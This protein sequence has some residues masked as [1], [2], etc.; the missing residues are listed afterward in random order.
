[1]ATV[2]PR[3][4]IST[5]C[6]VVLRSPGEED[7]LRFVA[8]D[9]DG[10]WWQRSEDAPDGEWEPIVPPRRRLPRGRAAKK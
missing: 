2:R 3:V 4:K 5:M 6:P 9:A 7:E 10:N 1:M 8:K